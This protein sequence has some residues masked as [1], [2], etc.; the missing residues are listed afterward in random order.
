[1]KISLTFKTLTNLKDSSK[2]TEVKKKCK[3]IA[4]HTDSQNREKEKEN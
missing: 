3:Q 1:M 4:R 2:E